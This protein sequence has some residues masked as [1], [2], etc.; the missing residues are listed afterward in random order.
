MKRIFWALCAL[1]CVVLVTACGGGNG[2]NGGAAGNNGGATP[3]PTPV[4]ALTPP[5]DFVVARANGVD[6]M[7]SDVR[8]H[9]PFSTDIM[10][11]EYWALNQSFTFDFTTLHPSGVTFYRAALEES[12]R[13]AVFFHTFMDM[14][15]DLGVIIS[16]EDYQWIHGEMAREQAA[17]P[18]GE[19]NNMIIEEGFRDI[20]HFMEF[21]I[22]SAVLDNLIFYLLTNDDAFAPFA[23]YIPEMPGMDDLPE[24][25]GAKHILTMFSQFETRA[26]AT[27]QANDILQRLHDGADF[28]TLMHQYSHDGGLFD[29]PLGYTFTEGDMQP[30]FEHGTRALEIGEISGLVET[31]FGYHIILRVEPTPPD[32]FRLMGIPFPSE[33]DLRVEAIFVAIQERVY[34]ADIE[35]LP[36]LDDL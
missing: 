7:A 5:P 30:E 35:F 13:T 33:Q 29:F 12:V 25:F 23:Q 15:A 36:A 27:A 17:R 21:L 31:I 1:L 26:A 34:A 22:G 9:L 32:W 18:P 20:D 4:A 6:I 2:D 19:F 28:T 11:D 8:I 16:D 14:A 10:M 24:L 3:A